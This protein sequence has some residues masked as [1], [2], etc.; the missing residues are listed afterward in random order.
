MAARCRFAATCT[1]S[2]SRCNHPSL[3]SF[4]EV[5][6]NDDTDLDWLEAEAPNLDLDMHG[7]DPMHHAP[8]EDFPGDTFPRPLGESP[9]A[10]LKA[11]R[12]P[13]EAGSEC[14]GARG[15]PRV[16]AAEGDH[17]EGQ[18]EHA[19]KRGR[20]D[21]GASDGKGAPT[22]D[23]EAPK[24]SRFER[25]EKRCQLRGALPACA[26]DAEPPRPFTRSC[27]EQPHPELAA[28]Q[29]AA[30]VAPESSDVA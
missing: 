10:A 2:L 17:S 19:R 23:E 28:L 5:L 6:L 1:G 15:S 22:E 13:L 14:A 24:M 3:P 27:R 18:A 12:L 11:P 8:P 29:D 7:M 26:W 4:T 9:Q 30:D 21:G 16:G 25:Y 20:E